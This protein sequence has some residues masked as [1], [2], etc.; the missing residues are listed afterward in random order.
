MDSRK[1]GNT[2]AFGW[3]GR[4]AGETLGELIKRGEH[5]HASI[6]LTKVMGKLPGCQTPWCAGAMFTAAEESAVR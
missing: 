6:P 5:L 1:P 2:T 3:A 4:P